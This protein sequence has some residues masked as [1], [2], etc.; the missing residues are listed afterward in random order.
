VDILVELAQGVRIRPQELRTFSSEHCPALDLFVAD[1]G[2]AVSCAN[3]S[4]V[5]AE[6]LLAL[7][8]RLEA[9]CFWTRAAGEL[10]ADIDWQFRIPLVVDFEPTSLLTNE[11]VSGK[12]LRSFR[13]HV[14]EV[15]AAGL[16]V[17][18]YIA[19]TAT[20]VAGFLVDTLRRLVTASNDLSPKGKGWKIRFKSEYDFQNLF[21]LAFKPWL[22]GL[23]REEITITYDSQKKSADFNLFYNQVIVEM[24]HV[25]NAN[26][27]A[28]VVKTLNGLGNFYENHP[29]VRVLVFA[30]L[31]AK[32][33]ELDDAKWESDFSYVERQP[34]VWTRIFREP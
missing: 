18:P 10:A 31:V 3:E 26:T 24:K 27:K 34:Q 16:P 28:A 7:V 1:G 21:F 8:S 15:A 9:I 4:C 32:N 20:E 11:P 25:R 17:Q 14:R 6:S 22:P 30:V 19:S 13:A 23:A 12:W 5:Q 2:K 33:V 29:N